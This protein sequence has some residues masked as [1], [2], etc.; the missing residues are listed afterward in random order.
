MGSLI[1]QEW[2][3]VEHSGVSRADARPGRFF[4]YVPDLLA[5]VQYVPSPRTADVVDR[6]N[7]ALTRADT[8]LGVSSQYFASL[9]V[10]SESI[11]SSFIE[12]Y[13]VTPKALAI[14]DAT[15]HGSLSAKAV[16]GNVRATTD[17]IGS[18]SDPGHTITVADLEWLQQTITP[19]AVHGVRTVQNWVGGPGYSPVRADFVPPPASYVPGLLDDLLGYLNST[20]GSPIVQ[21]AVVH[22]QFETVH[23]FTDGNGRT[24]RALIHA[25]LRRRDAVRNT[26]IP[27]STVFAAHTSTYLDGLAAFRAEKPDIDRWVSSFG[28]AIRIASEHAVV[29]SVRIE[30]QRELYAERLGRWRKEQGLVP[31]VPRVGSTISRILEDLPNTPVLTPRGI[32]ATY[33]V[34][35]PAA[36][37]A[38][39]ELVQSGVVHRVRD[40]RDGQALCYTANELLD[41]LSLTERSNAVGG[42]D[43][44]VIRPKRAPLRPQANLNSVVGGTRPLNHNGPAL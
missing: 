33:G 40:N 23:P 1:E 44:S 5:D 15:G 30:K 7:T 34:S 14:A 20:T 32:T 41:L 31:D 3:G 21:A 24:G 38:L 11:S 9:L 39:D 29:L 22:A 2:G 10:R 37:R 8:L 4:A 26:L 25:V 27:V 12:G 28:E 35:R 18:L 6:A 42:E 17:A 43:T 13:Q 36:H 19:N 16:L